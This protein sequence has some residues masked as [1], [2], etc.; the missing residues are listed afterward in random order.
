MWQL[1]SKSVCAPRQGHAIPALTALS[2]P[3]PHAAMP[4]IA[5]IPQPGGMKKN[6]QSLAVP[7]GTLGAGKP[8]SLAPR[9]LVIPPWWYLGA[10]HPANGALPLAMASKHH[11][12]SLGENAPHFWGSAA[13]G[14]SALGVGPRGD[15]ERWEP[16]GRRGDGDVGAEGE[17]LH[18]V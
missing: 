6:L 3:F 11:R 13:W 4:R 14:C 1:G 12:H 16:R 17:E 10:V 7:K 2:L 8:S 9:G 5:K 18:P 15:R